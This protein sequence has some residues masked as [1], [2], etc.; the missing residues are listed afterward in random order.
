MTGNILARQWHPRLGTSTDEAIRIPIL[1]VA[2]D[3]DGLIEAI[4][5]LKAYWFE[6]ALLPK[7]AGHE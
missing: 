3:F 4:K 6:I 1:I 2:L 7:E 5:R